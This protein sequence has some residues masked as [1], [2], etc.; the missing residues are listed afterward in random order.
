R[1]HFG[2]RARNRAPGCE[3]YQAGVEELVPTDISTTIAEGIA[4]SKPTRVRDVLRAAR[5]SGGGI[6]A[7][8]EDEIVSALG[9]LAR[10]GLY[11]EPTSAAGAAGLRQLLKAGAIATN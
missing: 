11:V 4:S 6:I 5:E 3:T 2:A 7:V 1:P 10:Q 8:S 9:V